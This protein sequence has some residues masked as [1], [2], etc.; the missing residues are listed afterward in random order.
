MRVVVAELCG[1][2]NGLKPNHPT[3]NQTIPLQTKPSHYK[4][5]HPTTN[6]TI[7]PQ[8]TPK[9]P[10]K[11]PKKPPKTRPHTSRGAFKGNWREVRSMRGESMV[12]RRW[13]MLAESRSAEKSRRRVVR[14][15]VA[16]LPQK[17]G[18]RG[19]EG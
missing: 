14:C 1:G 15:S 10:E 6:Q 16:L 7:P 18:L 3:T 19:E 11:T 8:S 13:L 5:N 17:K 2:G 12:S 4:P 9:F